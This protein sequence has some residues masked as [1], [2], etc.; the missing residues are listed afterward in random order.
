MEGDL[1]RIGTKI[2][3]DAARHESG[4]AIVGFRSGCIPSALHI[5]L[6]GDIWLGECAFVRGSVS[7]EDLAA[8][9]VA[10]SLA[11]A[12]SVAERELGRSVSFDKRFGLSELISILRDIDRSDSGADPGSC[13]LAFLAGQGTATIRFD[14][15]WLSGADAGQYRMA[16]K[17]LFPI[18]ST[19]IQIIRS[20]MSE[21]DEEKNW[22][23]ICVV[24]QAACQQPASEDGK[25]GMDGDSI[26]KL[27]EQADGQCQVE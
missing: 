16:R 8:I 4:H 19:D 14:G 3:I 20:V 6:E 11:H 26:L 1:E 21:L 23:A 22:R 18:D 13:D 24:A 12:K 25:F 5:R 7:A 15:A 2:Q 10:G 27:I 9:A 17:A